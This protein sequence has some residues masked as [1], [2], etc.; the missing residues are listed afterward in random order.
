MNWSDYSRLVGNIF[1]APAVAAGHQ[2]LG[3][4]LLLLAKLM[5]IVVVIFLPVVPDPN[6]G[7]P[8]Q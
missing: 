1:G 5:T 7:K 4:V 2:S 8:T 6:G 3:P